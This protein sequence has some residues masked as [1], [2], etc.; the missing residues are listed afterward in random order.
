MSIKLRQA[1]RRHAYLV[2]G[3]LSG[4]AEIVRADADFYTRSWSE[5]ADRGLKALPFVL[6]GLAARSMLS[7]D[8]ELPDGKDKDVL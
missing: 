4:V 5:L 8:P 7:K 6:L 2:A 3:I 1:I